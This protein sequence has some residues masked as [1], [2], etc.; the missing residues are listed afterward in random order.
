LTNKHKASSPKPPQILIDNNFSPLSIEIIKSLK[1]ANHQAYLVG[2]CVRDSLVGM[3]AK[4]FDVS[5]NATPEEIRKIFRSSR[6]I[7]KR[8]RLVH[9]FSRNELIEV[10]TFRANTSNLKSTS[11][12]V[13]DTD[14]KILRDNVWGNLEEDCVRNI[15]Q[16]RRFLINSFLNIS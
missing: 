12:I 2:G 16:K 7:G 13:K 11:E 8:F 6:I 9:V 14:G 10:S 1:K 5:T 4:D 15:A 3:K